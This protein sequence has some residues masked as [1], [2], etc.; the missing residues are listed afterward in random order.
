V[1]PIRWPVAPLLR[2]TSF[3]ILRAVRWI[4]VRVVILEA[5]I[6]VAL[7]VLGRFFS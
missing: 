7:V 3:D 2:R 6:I 1:R 4:Y 5:A